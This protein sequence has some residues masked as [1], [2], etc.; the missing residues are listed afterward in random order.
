MLQFSI[1]TLLLVVSLSSISAAVWL[2]WPA[3]QVIASTDEFHWHDHS[4]GVVDKCYQGGLQLRGQVRSDGH[5]ITLREGEDHLGTTG[6]WYYEVGIQLPND[7]DSDDVF[8][9]VPAA[10]G[11]HLEHVGKFDRLGFLQP[12]E[13]VAFYVGSPLKDCMACDD[14]DSSGSIKIISLSR[15]SVTIAVKLHASIPDSWDVDI[16]QTFTLPRE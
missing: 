9:L 3:E 12:C 14:P 15:E 7:I 1:R 11:R 5:Y 6:G 2:Y 4:V 10:S 13:F 8:D 16:D